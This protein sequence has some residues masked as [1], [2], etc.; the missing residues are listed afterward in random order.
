[1]KIIITGSS[2]RIGRAIFGALAARHEVTGIDRNPFSTTHIVGDCA[3]P[4]LLRR[5][6]DGADA[7]IHSAGPHAPHVGL[8]ADADFLRVNVEG[9]RSLAEIARASG[10][11]R[12]LYTSTTALYGDA[13]EPG[14]CTWIDEDTVPLPK[15][16]YHR[17]KLAAEALLEELASAEMSV[18]ILRMS[19]CFPEP[20]PLMAAYRLHRGVDARDVAAGHALA[21]TDQGAAFERFVLSGET[22][23]AREDCEGLAKDAPEVIRARAPALAAEFAKRGWDLPRSIDRVYSS[24]RAQDR[25]GWRARQGWQ[26]VLAQADRDDL[27]VLPAGSHIARKAE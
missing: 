25:L 12:L 8:V 13:V 9:T 20:A 11:T 3:D 18:R 21:L 19:R 1:M 22:V 6:L 23:F 4:E 26:E 15:S 5:A 16:I 10:V 7:V 27:E 2:G 24:A 17:T 14:R